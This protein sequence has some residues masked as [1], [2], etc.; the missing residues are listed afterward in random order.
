[1]SVPHEL[2]P[3]TLVLPDRA[4]WF[5]FNGIHPIER[6]AI[7]WIKRKIGTDAEQE[8]VLVRSWIIVLYHRS[9]C[10]YLSMTTC[11]SYFNADVTRVYTIWNFL[12]EWQIINFQAQP[13]TCT[14][15]APPV[16]CSPGTM[17]V[18]ISV[19]EAEWPVAAAVM[20]AAQLADDMCD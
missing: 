19:D 18:P 13:H 16:V 3:S 20:L 8:Y 5:S 7:P 1:V 12:N 14:V 2:L 11:R 15:Y 6:E 9:P 17:S 10:Q 4:S